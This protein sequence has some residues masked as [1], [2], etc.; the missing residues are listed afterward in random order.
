MLKFAS[1]L[2][3]DFLIEEKGGV[4]SH[5]GTLNEIA[6]VHAMERY[7]HFFNK[8][9]GDHKKAIIDLIKEGHIDHK[10]YNGDY[11]DKI[12]KAKLGIGEKETDRTLWDSHHAAI[13]LLNYIHKTKGGISGPAVWTGPDT[14]GKTVEKITGV[15]TQADILIPTKSGE[16]IVIERPNK[17]SKDD[18]QHSSLKYS[19]KLDKSPTKL[20][21]GTAADAAEMI[22]QHHV[23]H[24]GK[25]DE[26]LDRAVSNINSAFS[27]VG[28]KLKSKA[29]VLAAAG[30][31]PDSK[32]EFPV[33]RIS[34]LARYAHTALNHKDANERNKRKAQFEKHL[35]ESGIPKREWNNH[36]KN[37]AD[38]HENVIKSDKV[39][40]SKE[41]SDAFHN[42]LKKSWNEASSGQ[43]GLLRSLLNIRE[44]RN[45][46]VMV[47]KTQR[48]HKVDYEKDPVGALPK[49]S[50]AKHG[51]DLEAL[52][53]RG[54]REGRNESQLYDNVKK[55]QESASTTISKRN[56]KGI[57]SFS[58]DTGKTSPSLIAQAG[59]EIDNFKDISDL[60]P[61]HPS[62][63]PSDQ[64]V[65][66]PKKI[67][68]PA[69]PQPAPSST[70][71]SSHGGKKW[72]P[73]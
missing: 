45:A 54:L 67:S 66:K 51:N 41:F 31:V 20:F 16:K 24:F 17:K 15:N 3:E 58:I 36:F 34:K 47:V 64:I 12:K 26:N 59:Q 18:W 30:I 7:N 52:M 22:Q 46:T 32:G 43:H 63:R 10:K 2:V 68:T 72:S 53:R 57:A 61:S 49:V 35:L 6:F 33:T 73:L 19:E 62:Y 25:R 23:E 55:K 37:L 40:A 27:D 29:N 60:H 38:I 56:G 1:F 50:L 65:A 11:S 8:H 70:Y 21:Q 42:A 4:V 44:R 14:T 13:A 9:N 28:E 71:D 39:I 5:R 48:N 69:P